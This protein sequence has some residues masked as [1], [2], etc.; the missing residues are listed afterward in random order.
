MALEETDE[1]LCSPQVNC[2]LL[3]AKAGGEE[4]LLCRFSMR[5]LVRQSYAARGATLFLSL[6][7]I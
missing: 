6:I 4:R 5:H 3:L 7:H 2:G 1:I